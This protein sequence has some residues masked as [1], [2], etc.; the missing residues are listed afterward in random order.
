MLNEVSKIGSYL[1]IMNHCVLIMLVAIACWTIVKAW[2]RYL[3]WICFCQQREPVTASTL[4]H[5]VI[6][7]DSLNTI[8][9]PLYRIPLNYRQISAID[10]NI[11][12]N[13]K[14]LWH[15]CF[16][17]LT[18]ESEAI[19]V[20]AHD[21]SDTFVLPEKIRLHLLT[22]WRLSRLL[23]KPHTIQIIL[24][25]EGFTHCIARRIGNI[26]NKREKQNRMYEF[27]GLKPSWQS[28]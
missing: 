28:N 21:S 5:F 14:V 15:G 12:V 2:Q 11:N 19:T 8:S 1:K 20:K 7:D 23:L 17:F 24:K 3:K 18:W 10:H 9:F 27:L 25:N 4:V 16:P 6:W 22:G 13:A 26:R